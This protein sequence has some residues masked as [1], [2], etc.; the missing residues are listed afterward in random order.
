MIAASKMALN[1][2][3]NNTSNLNDPYKLLL[4]W[5]FSSVLV[6]FRTSGKLALQRSSRQQPLTYLWVLR[7]LKKKKNYVKWHQN[8][9]IL[10][11]DDL[12]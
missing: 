2:I 8:D 12:K 3:G 6:I 1:M 10:Q 11:H 5:L 4:L 9:L 7:R